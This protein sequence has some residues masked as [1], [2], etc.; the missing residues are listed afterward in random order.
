MKIAKQDVYSH[1]VKDAELTLTGKD[2]DG[3]EIIF[4]EGT[5]DLGEG[6]QLVKGSGNSIIWKSGDEATTVTLTDGTYLLKEL[7]APEGFQVATDMTFEI[8]DGKLVTIDGEETDTDT[9]VMVDEMIV[10]TT[11]TTT[12]TTA[13]TTT[14]IDVMGD[15]VT[16]TTTTEDIDVGGGSA[17]RTTITTT[18]AAE[19]TTTTAADEDVDVD[20]GSVTRTTTT[21]TKKAPAKT[22][23]AAPKTDAPRTGVSGIS[24]VTAIMAFA[25]L[26]AFAARSRKK[27]EDD[28]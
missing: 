20:G 6:A 24:A 11:T 18:D 10:T 17:T 28:E 9:V 23:T 19:T 16:N 8:R 7:T 2:T 21:T 15:A 5:V 3:N 14:T 1:E 13:T 25:T 27:E 12:T 4:E 26:A 22:T